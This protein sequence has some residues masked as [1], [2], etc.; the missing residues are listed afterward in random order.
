MGFT[1]QEVYHSAYQSSFT[2][3]FGDVDPDQ[4]WDFTTRAK[5]EYSSVANEDGYYYVEESTLT[6]LKTNLKENVNNKSKGTAFTLKSDEETVFEIVPLYTGQASYDWSV[7]VVIVTEDGTK[8][9]QRIWTKGQDGIQEYGKDRYYDEGGFWGWGAGWKERD[10][11]GWYEIGKDGDRY[12]YATSEN[13]TQLRSKTTQ[14][15]VPAN[16]TIYFQVNSTG[17]KLSTGTSI[18]AD[19]SILCLNE[20]PSTGIKTKFPDYNVKVIGVEAYSPK[21][22]DHTDVPGP[23]FNEFVFF[24]TGY[25]PQVIYN[26]KV[27]VETSTKRYMMED[28]GSI[29]WDFNDVVVDVT[30]TTRTQYLI[31][32]DTGEATVKPGTT[33]SVSYSAVIAH[34]GGTYPVQV[35]VGTTALPLIS[36]PTNHEQTNAELAGNSSTHTCGH[37]GTHNDGWEPNSP[38]FT[39]TGYTPAGNNVSLTV[40]KDYDA[41]QKVNSESVWTS[42]FPELGAVPYIIATDPTDDWTTEGVGVDTKD[43]WKQRYPTTTIK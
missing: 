34:L 33:P 25:V 43:W 31:N 30:T 40:Y 29:D 16:S 28:M 14:I 7:D 35:T 3:T 17:E 8:T 37:N 27:T 13:A 12:R 32:T 41:S 5:T 23:D 26:D 1:Q 19:P 2:K 38:T 9:T 6:W 39:I 24:L 42:T 15:N 10:P 22:S 4:N 21:A 20:C 36:D 18:A 11:E